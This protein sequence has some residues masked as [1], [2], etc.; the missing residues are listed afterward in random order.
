V[1]DAGLALQETSK[2]LM[3]AAR[4]TEAVAHTGGF[5]GLRDGIR[6]LRLLSEV[7]WDWLR[8]KIEEPDDLEARSAAFNWLDDPDRGARFPV[9]VRGLPLIPGSPAP[10]SWAVW[11]QMQT[12]KSQV[13]IPDFEKAVQDVQRAHCQTVVDDLGAAWEEAEALTVVLNEKMGTYAPGLSS[14]RSAV[15][16][17]LMLARQLLERKWPE[18]SEAAEGLAAEAGVAGGEDET[19]SP[20]G[21][22]VGRTVRSRADIYKRLQEAAE[23][24]QQVDPQSPIPYIIRR[25]I[26]LGELPFP[27]LMKALI[28]DSAVLNDLARNLGIEELSQ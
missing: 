28:S 6:L 11:N 18:P 20:Q 17:C 13:T 19:G 4:L 12:G 22:L 26:A 2:D 24:L 7:S 9:T 15:R 3:L 21:S 25:A 23:L 16:D 8:P 27:D 1:R 10:I 5:A 14:F